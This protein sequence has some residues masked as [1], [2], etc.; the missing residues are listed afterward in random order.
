MKII[1][2]IFLSFVLIVANAQDTTVLVDNMRFTL[3]EV[4]VRN[5]M[6]YKSILQRIQNDTSFYKAF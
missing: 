6:D 5:N 2:T 4:V 3:R 1:A